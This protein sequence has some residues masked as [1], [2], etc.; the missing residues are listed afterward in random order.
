MRKHVTLALDFSEEPQNMAFVATSL[1]LAIEHYRDNEGI[2]DEADPAIFQK[3]SVL[4]A[5]TPVAPLL[6]LPPSPPSMTREQAETIIYQAA[7]D[8]MGFFIDDTDEARVEEMDM[9]QR[10]FDVV[11]TKR[12]AWDRNELQFPRLLAE[13]HGVLEKSQFRDLAAAMDLDVD[14]VGD[15]FDRADAEWERIKGEG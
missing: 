6:P 1:A 10:A 9:I 12:D 8:Y 5:S 14:Q 3:V 15:L 2:T 13:V 7:Q 11:N 4:D